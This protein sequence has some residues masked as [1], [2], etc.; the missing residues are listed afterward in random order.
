[1]LLHLLKHPA[2]S[3]GEEKRLSWQAMLETIPEPAKTEKDGHILYA[4][5]ESWERVSNIEFPQL[6]PLFP[7]G[8][9]GLG[10]ADLDG[11]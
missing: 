6:Y 2:G 11:H 4:P 1:M 7:Y 8:L 9:T 10:K 3:L 5:A